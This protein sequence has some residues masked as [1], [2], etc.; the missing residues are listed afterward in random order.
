MAQINTML[1][2]RPLLPSGFMRELEA[3]NEDEQV[4]ILS[5]LKK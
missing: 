1:D 3:R 5:F 4:S 2:Y